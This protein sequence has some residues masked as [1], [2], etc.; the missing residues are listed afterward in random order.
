VEFDNRGDIGPG[1]VTDL[2]AVGSGVD[3]RT[4]GQ[5]G[6]EGIDEAA[7]S[8]DVTSWVRAP[9]MLPVSG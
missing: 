4:G 7:R 6:A 3:R 5:V 8:D 9:K 1:P 2:P